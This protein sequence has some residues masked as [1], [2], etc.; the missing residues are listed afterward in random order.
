MNIKDLKEAQV[1]AQRLGVKSLIYGPAGSGKTPVINTAPRPLLLATEPG[2]LSMRGSTVPTF[3]APTGKDIDAFFLWFFSSNET[4]NF[5]TLAIDSGTQIAETF[6]KEA[7]KTNKHGLAAYGE[8]N[9]NTLQHLEQ[10]YFMPQKHIYLIAKQ[11]S[12][13]DNTKRPYWPGRELPVKLAHMY[14]QILH[15]DIHNV[16]GVGQVRSFQCGQTFDIMAR[17]RTGILDIYEQPDFGK[18]VAKVMA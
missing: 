9:K 8:A 13:A 3:I 6:L 11:D 12:M 17:D 14:D 16:P 2:L 18:I 4:K 5:D 15:L 1:Y 7:E 10:L